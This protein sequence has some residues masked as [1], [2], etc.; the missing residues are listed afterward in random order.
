MKILTKEKSIAAV[1]CLFLGGFGIHRFY[2]KHTKSAI[3]MLVLGV[4]LPPV[5]QVWSV[6][7]LFLI[8]FGKIIKKNKNN[9]LTTNTMV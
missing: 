8:L 7:D 4:L 1:L 6:V 3:V 5:T 2:L 9:S